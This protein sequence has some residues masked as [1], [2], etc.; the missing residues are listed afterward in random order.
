MDERAVGNWI[1]KRKHLFK[2]RPGRLKPARMHQVATGGEVTQ[3]EPS[4]I[5]SLAAQTQQTLIQV[6]R[7]IQFA[8]EHAIARL[9]IGNVKELRGEAQLLPQLPGASISLTRFRRCLAFDRKQDRAQGAPKLELLLLALAVVRQ[10][11]FERA[12][13]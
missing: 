4:R 2:M 3:N 13:D 12:G 8:T 6:Q 11:R 1:M 5:I 9:P 10:M 7:Q